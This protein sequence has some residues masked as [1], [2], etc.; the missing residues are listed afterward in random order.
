MLWIPWNI[1]YKCSSQP[2]ICTQNPQGLLQQEY[3]L[4]ADIMQ[5]LKC[6]LSIWV[7]HVSRSTAIFGGWMDDD[8]FLQLK[9]EQ[10]LFMYDLNLLQTVMN[11]L[12]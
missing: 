3:G 10:L 12:E 11:K 8:N 5:D 7:L 1:Q 4:L 2:N 6:L 9:D